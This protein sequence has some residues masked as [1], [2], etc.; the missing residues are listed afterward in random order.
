MPP[1]TTEVY[2]PARI[3]RG[4]PAGLKRGSD[5][6]ESASCSAAVVAAAGIAVEL[7]LICSSFLL[8]FIRK[9]AAP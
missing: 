9:G 3:P 7:R 4:D 2:R 1:V 6:S 8:R 5:G